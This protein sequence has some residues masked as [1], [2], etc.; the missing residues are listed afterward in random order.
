MSNEDKQ[1]IDAALSGLW[2]YLAAIQMQDINT[3]E[4][5][6]RFRGARGYFNQLS[7][8]IEKLTNA[9]RDVFCPMCGHD[10]RRKQ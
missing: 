2:N 6:E 9:H 7:S 10:L 1:A 3:N 5:T 8:L 4:G